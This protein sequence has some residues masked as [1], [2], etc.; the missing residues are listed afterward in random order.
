MNRRGEK[1]EVAGRKKSPALAK[2]KR[3]INKKHWKANHQYIYLENR[4]FSTWR[5]VRAEGT[6]VNDSNFA[7]WQ[8]AARFVAPNE[9]VNS[10]QFQFFFNIFRAVFNIYTGKK[11][12]EYLLISFVEW[13]TWKRLD[14]P[15]EK[16]WPKKVLC[17]LGARITIYYSIYL[18]FLALVSFVT[19]IAKSINFD[20][21]GKMQKCSPFSDCKSE[22]MWKVSDK[23][24]N[25]FL[26][27]FV[28]SLRDLVLRCSEIPLN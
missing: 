12:S 7:S 16:D 28:Y 14:H 8:M 21:I 10:D 5:K 18:H 19:I 23:L 2:I 24:K 6:F 22:L 9:D 17:A 20:S 26:S 1:R 27:F 25:C 11:C 15:K 4:V 13:T 3:Q